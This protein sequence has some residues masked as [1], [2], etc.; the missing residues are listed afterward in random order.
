M[1]SGNRG[2]PAGRPQ[3]HRG[4]SGK[5]GC[6]FSVLPPAGD[7]SNRAGLGQDLLPV[8]SGEARNQGD[9]HPRPLRPE[10]PTEAHRRLRFPNIWPL[11]EE[12]AAAE[13]GCPLREHTQGSAPLLGRGGGGLLRG[14]G[15]QG[16]ADSR[17][18][19]NCG[20]S[21][22]RPLG[23]S[24]GPY[25]VLS[26]KLPTRSAGRSHETAVITAGAGGGGAS[27]GG[28]EAVGPQVPGQP[29]QLSGQC[30]KLKIGLGM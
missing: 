9:R 27:A 19:H 17:H 16:E 15:A 29:G 11:G 13:S 4:F 30:F 22:N 12:R 6:G 10:A 25:P 3:S 5:L 8:P 23:R 26:Q 14:G 1:W 28:P 20:A 24:R 21:P 18:P 2:H 7:L